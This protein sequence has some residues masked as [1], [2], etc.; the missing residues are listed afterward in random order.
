MVVA[1]QILV[2]KICQ[3]AVLGFVAHAAGTVNT[4]QTHRVSKR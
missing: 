1:L 3:V 2:G 4:R